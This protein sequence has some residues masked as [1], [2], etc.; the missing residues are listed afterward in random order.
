MKIKTF[1]LIVLL[2]FCI[3]IAAL[4]SDLQIESSIY[5][6]FSLTKLVE[7]FSSASIAFGRPIKGGPG[8]D[9]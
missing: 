9:L 3:G 5:S 6:P 8:S 4:T 7:A 1:T 2:A